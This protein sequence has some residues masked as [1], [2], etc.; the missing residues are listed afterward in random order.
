MPYALPLPCSAGLVPA[1]DRGMAAAC[2]LSPPGRRYPYLDFRKFPTPTL[3]ALPIGMLREHVNP[4]NIL[5]FLLALPSP[6]ILSPDYGEFPRPY[7]MLCPYPCSA[8]LNPLSET[9]E[10][11]PSPGRLPHYL[12]YLLSS[13]PHSSVGIANSSTTTS[14]VSSSTTAGMNS[15]MYTSSA[16]PPSMAG[17][18]RMMPSRS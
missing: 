17:M 6:I 14:S 18:F 8:G 5:V 9:Q 16:A 12:Y 4:E 3:P 15:S 2:F 13:S 1:R 7:L 11:A 10:G